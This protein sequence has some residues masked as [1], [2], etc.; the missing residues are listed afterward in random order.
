MPR[1]DSKWPPRG[2]S[3]I[4]WLTLAAVVVGLGITLLTQAAADRERGAADRERVANHI[5]SAKPKLDD[6]GVIKITVAVTAAQVNA[7]AAAIKKVDEKQDQIL[8]KLD[9]PA[10]RHR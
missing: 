2:G 7:N 5:S 8:E 4:G 3:L 10:R 1:T 9:R 6:V